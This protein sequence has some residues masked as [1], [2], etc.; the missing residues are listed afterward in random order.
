[1]GAEVDD[2]MTEG[3]GGIHVNIHRMYATEYDNKIINIH[4]TNSNH[5]G[6]QAER[7]GTNSIGWLAS[8]LL[9]MYS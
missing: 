2:K 4:I 1:M 6:S 7:S 9:A 3:E 5:T 8:K